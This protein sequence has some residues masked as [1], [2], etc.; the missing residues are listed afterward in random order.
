MNLAVRVLRH[1][2]LQREA[3]RIDLDRDGR[4]ASSSAR[5]SDPQARPIL[6]N[7]VGTADPE[8]GNHPSHRVM[9][10]TKF[11]RRPKAESGQ[12]P[13]LG[14]LSAG[15]SGAPARA[16]HTGPG[17]QLLTKS[18]TS[19]TATALRGCEAQ[20]GVHTAAR[21]L[22]SQ[23]PWSNCTPPAARHADRPAATGLTAGGPRCF[24]DRG[25]SV[26]GLRPP[27]RLLRAGVTTT[28][29]DGKRPVSDAVDLSY[30]T[31]DIPVP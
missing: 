19:A 24:V 6:Q 3:S 30:R 21:P 13:D 1:G 9:S 22:A 10:C 2:S 26:P 17:A 8:G 15:W 20:R 29:G 4:A 23:V 16:A 27:A 31:S 25:T 12:P 7:Q 28:L 14:R 5:V 18:V 11:Y